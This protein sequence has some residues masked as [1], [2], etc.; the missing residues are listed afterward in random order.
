MNVIKRDGTVEAFDSGKL[1][2]WAIWSRG[3]LENV[4]W[5][6]IAMDTYAILPNPV[7]TRTIQ[8]KLIE[9]CNMRGSWEYSVM[10]GRLYSS[11]IEKDMYPNG[12][13]TIKELHS[14][15]VDLGLMMDLGYT[16]EEYLALEAIIQHEKNH[17]YAHFQIEYIVGKY[18][19]QNRVMGI[20]F[21]TPQFVYMRMAMALYQDSDENLRLAD[22]EKMYT[23]LSNNIIS[24][25]TPNYINLGTK[26]NGYASCCVYA[27]E[28][29]ATSLAAGDHIAYMMTCM[30]AG[31]GNNLL[32]RSLNEP[33]RDG[34]ISHQ[35]KLPYYR[36]L[37]GAVKAN[38]QQG[39]GGSCT[40]YFS[41]YDPEV[42]TILRLMNP[43]S[44]K[45]K[46][47]RDLD[48]C[49]LTNRLFAKK[50]INNEDVFVF[51]VKTAPDLHALFYS[52]DSDAFEAKY[53]EYE[54][55]ET[56]KKTYVNPRRII[57]TAGQEAYESGTL[58]YMVVDEAN[59]H[60]PFKDK[61]YSSNLCN[62]IQE[63]TVP[64]ANVKDL[65]SE[66]LVGWT[67]ITVPGLDGSSGAVK[68]IV[69]NKTKLSIGVDY[70]TKSVSPLCLRPGDDTYAYG[71]ILDIKT[72]TPEPEIALCN[73]AAINV[74]ND[75]TDE[76]Y[77]EAM[78]YALVMIE[79]TIS[80]NHYIFPHLAI[81]AKSRLNAGVG[82][83]GL[84]THMA[85]LNL[86]YDSV[87][88]RNEIHRVAE[89]HMY[90][91]IKASLAL[92][93]V[94][95]VAPWIRR[96]KWVD[97]W[98]P[99]DTYNRNVDEL[100]TVGLQYDWETL[101]SEVVANGGIRNST[102]VAHMPTESSSKASGAPNGVYPVRSICL[103]KTD[104]SSV[105]DWV[106]KDSD[107][108]GDNYQ[109][110]WDIATEDILKVY[111]VIQKFTDQSISADT[112]VDRSDV[113]SVKT[114]AMYNDYLTMVKYGVKGRYYQNVKT[115]KGVKASTSCAGGN[116][117]L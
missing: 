100:V 56:F 83:I 50:L 105:I 11:M 41:C 1:N 115:S 3:G 59:R 82:M 95:G 20:R 24:A 74:S 91:A 25:P 36:S 90:F 69:P 117:K 21:E 46:S 26:L 5:S 13:P 93:K 40:T 110:A 48:F 77:F 76:E 62:E 71:K 14:Q 30:S 68:K 33:V 108:L 45:D 85:K 8:L 72:V 19:I 86:R 104:A 112:Y 87:E 97:G 106:A 47:N 23:Y 61:I 7:P 16:D 60:T 44:V 96:T 18:S 27:V 84:A 94:L 57:A 73:L 17:D 37:A 67:E 109:L 54:L 64:Y 38:V 53:K 55:D 15:L 113:I 49:L 101:R 43:R 52:G 2:K 32:T 66:D 31:I 116:C 6:S 114:S 4:D 29:T 79:N 89:R 9:S 103:K 98:M 12:V 107:T 99:I 80:L 75:M 65:Y 78:Y 28:D 81:T 35:G 70:V 22:V 58:Y 10:A 102:L 92:S 63:P 111:A 88:G 34:A 51:S 39:R 42:D